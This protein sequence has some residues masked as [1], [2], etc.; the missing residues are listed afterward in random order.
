[1]EEPVM[2][3][4]LRFVARRLDGEAMSEV[5]RAFG[6]SGKTGGKI[7]DRYKEH[8][9][10][11]LTD[12]SRR[13]VRSANQRPPQIEGLIVSLK[14]PSSGTSRIGH[15][16]ALVRRRDGDLRGPAKSTNHAVLHRHRLVKPIGRPRH[17]ACTPLSTGA[18]P[19]PPGGAAPGSSPGVK[20]GNGQYCSPLT[21]TDHAARFLLLGEALASTREDLAVTAFAQLFQE[22]GLPQAIRSANGVP[23]ASPK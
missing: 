18:A 9:L 4:R 15:P 22:R 21:V 16:R 1:M 12:R 13:P 7:F 5:C 8:G 23:F 10:E 20:L 19:N 3:E 2:E 14:R 6:I 11:A 17:R